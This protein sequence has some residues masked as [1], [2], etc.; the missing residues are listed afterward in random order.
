[1]RAFTQLSFTKKKHETGDIYTFYFTPK[2]PL[3]HKAGQHGLFILP[4]L[5]RPHPFTLSSAPDEDYVTISTHI[6]T[7][8]RYKKRLMNLKRGDKMQ[9]VGPILDFTIQPNETNHV[10][11]AQGIGITPFRSM[12]VDAHNEKLPI[13]TTLIHVDKSDHAFQSITRKT[14]THAHYPKSSQEFNFYMNDL[15]T[16]SLFYISGSPHFI[17]QTR[18]YLLEMGVASNR[19]KSDLFFGY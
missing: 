7:G 19:I 6:D 14:A 16:S 17:R 11:L 8:S 9:L 3:K 18:K 13:K 2:K 10:F 5:Y 4:G 12:L 1:M 15:D